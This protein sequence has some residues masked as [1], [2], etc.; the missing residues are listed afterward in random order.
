MLETDIRTQR[1]AE[2]LRLHTLSPEDMRKLIEDKL[3]RAEEH[4]NA[5]RKR[6]ELC[7]DR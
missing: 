2:F 1:Q 6:E 5:V 3:K 4:Y 7:G